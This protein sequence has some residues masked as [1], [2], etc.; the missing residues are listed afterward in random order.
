MAK[1][2]NSIS[3]FDMVVKEMERLAWIVGLKPEGDF[4]QF[5]WKGI[6]IHAVNTVLYHIPD[7]LPE[8]GRR[9]LVLT[10]AYPCQFHSDPA[11]SIQ[12]DV[13]AAA[14]NITDLDGKQRLLFVSFFQLIFYNVVKGVFDKRLNKL[15]RG[16]V[17]A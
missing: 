15:I 2:N 8:G 14:R 4:A 3:T 9:G 5:N 13:A 6:F 16:V 12:E 7:C 11:S 17:R 1:P 10:G